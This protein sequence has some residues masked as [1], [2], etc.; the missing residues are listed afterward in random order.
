MPVEEIPAK[1]K[2][3]IGLLYLTR[4]KVLLEVP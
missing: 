1:F 3:L 2:K 4:E